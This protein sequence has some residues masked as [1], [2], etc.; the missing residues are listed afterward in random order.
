MDEKTEQLRDIFVD[1]TGADT[2]T[3][4][5]EE[6]RGSLSDAEEDIERRIESLVERMRERYDFRTDLSVE[7]LREVVV[8]FFDDAE[9]EAITE[10]LGVDSETI[11]D[12]RM[13]LHLLR[14]SDREPPF[15]LDDLRE[16]VVE[17]VPIEVRAARLD[18]DVA[19]VEHYSQVVAAELAS[20]RANLRFVDEFTD[21][22]TD[23]EL[24]ESHAANARE[25]G[26]EE[27]AEDIE[28][29]TQL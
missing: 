8:E 2:V 20:T 10:A 26:L 17:A 19:T 12:A 7:Q 16:L 22:L 18:T 21:L 6:E 11:F 4:S 3:E 24:S 1:T 5:Q 13:D 9:D 28:T 14:D 15:S 23:A 29:N 25:S 27:A